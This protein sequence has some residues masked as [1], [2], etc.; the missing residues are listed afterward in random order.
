MSAPIYTASGQKSALSIKLDSDIV[1]LKV[2]NFQL[3]K[4]VYMSYLANN[5]VNLAQTKTR[6]LIRGGGRKPWKQKGTGRARFG[7][8]RNPIWRGGGIVFGPSGNRNFSITVGKTEKRLALKQALSL[9]WQSNKVVIVEKYPDKINK[10]A[11]VAKWL[12]K[13][14]QAK[15]LL[16]VSQVM[17]KSL[18]LAINNLRFVHICPVDLLKPY[19]VINAD[20]LIFDAGSVAYLNN[21]AK[22]SKKADK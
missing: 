9:A 22:L 2:K 19:D 5:R 17:P 18:E 15:N 1:G 12:R 13:I 8:S 6:G 21:R 4:K 10:T 7:S 14:S 3:L 16:V 20:G 11:D